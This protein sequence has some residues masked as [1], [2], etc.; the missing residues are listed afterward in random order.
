MTLVRAQ[1]APLL[2]GLLCSL[3]TGAVAQQRSPRPGSHAPMGPRAQPAHLQPTHVTSPIKTAPA[4]PA[5]VRPGNGASSN[6]VLQSGPTG[7]AIPASAT[8]SPGPAIG[9][10]AS[11]PAVIGAPPPGSMIHQPAP[12][13]PLSDVVAPGNVRI[14]IRAISAA[15]QGLAAQPLDID[16]RLSPIGKDL[17]SFA[18]QFSYRNYRLLDVQTFD[19]DFR[20]IAQMELPGQ[21]AIAVEPRQ[22]AEDGRVKVHLELLGQH[23]EHAPR[24]RADY[25]I[26][27]GATIFVGGYKIAPEGGTLLLAITQDE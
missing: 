5:L 6:L 4:Q 7:G 24:M 21:R 18:E 14:T 23:P 25:S 1:L 12:R 9:P 27:R 19:L 16:G 26:S 15:G 8:L 2:F 11:A 13:Q 22:L 20:S 3:A 10:A 17:R